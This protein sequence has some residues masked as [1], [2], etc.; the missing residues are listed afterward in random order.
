MEGEEGWIRPVQRAEDLEAGLG[1]GLVDQA[2]GGF[3]CLA[4]RAVENQVNGES[5][6]NAG[7]DLDVCARYDVV[8]AVGQGV[9]L[10]QQNGEEFERQSRGSL[11]CDFECARKKKTCYWND[12][13]QFEGDCRHNCKRSATSSPHC[14]KKVRVHARIDCRF[15]PI[16]QDHCVL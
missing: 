9:D 10:G 14:P 12:G 6:E 13:V 7:D 5:A 1:Q 15:G 8:R 2:R 4:L 11:I 16:G 3:H